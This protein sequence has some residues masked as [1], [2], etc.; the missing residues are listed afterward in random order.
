MYDECTLEEIEAYRKLE[1]EK[2]DF[3]EGEI[4]IEGIYGSED[5]YYELSLQ[6]MCDDN[7]DDNNY[8]DIIENK[9]KIHKIKTNKY[10]RKLNEKLKLEKLYNEINHN[11]NYFINIVHT[12]EG[13]SYYKRYYLSYN[14]LTK[15]FKH[16]S[17][18][19]VRKCRCLSG[20]GSNYKKVFDY[21]GKVF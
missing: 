4:R 21:K 10:E 18:K 14:G 9:R 11:Y 20:K 5:A 17:N 19:K 12:K 2:F 3:G 7:N 8:N 1:S 15:F 13:K 6:E 16:M